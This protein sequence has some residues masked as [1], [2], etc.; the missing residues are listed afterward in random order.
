MSWDK[1]PPFNLGNNVNKFITILKKAYTIHI[2]P[3]LATYPK[4]EA[5][6]VKAAKDLLDYGIY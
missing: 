5:E 6:F 1:K 2:I 4:L 3:E